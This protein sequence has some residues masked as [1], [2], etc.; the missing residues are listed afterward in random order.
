MNYRKQ[1]HPNSQLFFY[2]KNQMVSLFEQLNTD[3][4]DTY[5]I[6]LSSEGIVFQVRK[7]NDHD[8]TWTILVAPHEVA[9]ALAAVD[10][11]QRENRTVSPAPQDDT[12]RFALGAGLWSAIVLLIAYLLFYDSP[13]AAQRI[14]DFGAAAGKIVDGEWHRTVTALL[15]HADAVH[16]LGNMVGLTLFG[17][18]VCTYLG[19]GLGWFLILASGIIGNWANAY[20]YQGSAH[21][22]VGASTA[23]FG[24][25]GIISAYRLIRM[26]RL[27]G[28]KIRTFL[29]LGGGLALLAL[30]GSSAHTDITAHF[31]G[32]GA[33]TVLGGGYALLVKQL[34]SKRYQICYLTITVV[35][36]LAAW[37]QGTIYG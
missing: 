24:A 3:Q 5:A 1:A 23:V 33:G 26:Q 30:L 17:A 4:A 16:L 11:Y 25:I 21:L 6:V 20:L 8:S 13:Q 28:K 32:F 29:P 7:N 18:A 37:T 36:L 9:R 10:A 2:E 27:P 15:I 35:L 19:W 12:P 34:L 14:R 22:S 31:L